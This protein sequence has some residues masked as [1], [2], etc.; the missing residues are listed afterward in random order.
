MSVDEIATRLPKRGNLHLPRCPF[1]SSANS[2]GVTSYPFLSRVSDSHCKDD[3]FTKPFTSWRYGSG[4][5]SFC[6]VHRRCVLRLSSS[7]SCFSRM[8]PTLAIKGKESGKARILRSGISGTL[9]VLLSVHH[10]E[11]C[12]RQVSP[13]RSSR[14]YIIDY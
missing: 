13:S 2:S 4:L 5:E 7:L 10:R 14:S 6:E 11:D 1:Q 3:S 8:S 9:T 12:G